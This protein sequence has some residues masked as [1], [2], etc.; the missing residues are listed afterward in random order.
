M[1]RDQRAPPADESGEHNALVVIFGDAGDAPQK[2]GVMYEQEVG[3]RRN[4]L[5]RDIRHRIDR[6]VEGRNGRT[7][8]PGEQAGRVPA[9]RTG[10]RPEPFDNGADIRDGARGRGERH[11]PILVSSEG[12][13]C[14]SVPMSLPR[15]VRDACLRS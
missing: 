9:L 15:Q 11:P 4:G 10:D 13:G 2:K 3:A 1:G 5:I 8:T 7:G 12:G 6:E 14:G